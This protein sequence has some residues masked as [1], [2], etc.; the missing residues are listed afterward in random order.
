MLKMQHSLQRGWRGW[1]LVMLK[2]QR[3]VQ[4]ERG[5]DVLWWCSRCNI[6][7]REGGGADVLQSSR[8]DVVFRGGD[9]VF[10]GG[11]WVDLRRCNIVFKRGGGA[12]VSRCNVLFIGGGGVDVLWWW[13]CNIVFRG[14]ARAIVLW[15]WRCN[16]VFRGGGGDDVL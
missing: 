9:I 1:C 4:R 12:D 13:R 3:I 10:R 2:V 11:R 5:A 6:V 14:G 15:P 16:I 8:G 7:L